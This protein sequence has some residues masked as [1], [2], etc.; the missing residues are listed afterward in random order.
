[1]RGSANS[2]L[3][4]SLSRSLA[5]SLSGIACAACGSALSS[6]AVPP[7]AVPSE[8]RAEPLVAQAQGRAPPVPCAPGS[9]DPSSVLQTFFKHASS[10]PFRS[11]A[12]DANIFRAT[13][14][15]YLRTRLSRLAMRSSHTRRGRRSA[16]RRPRCTTCRRPTGRRRRPSPTGSPLA[17]ARTSAR[18]C[19]RCTRAFRVPAQVG[20]SA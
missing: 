11:Q 10:I 18:S 13:A 12:A 1:L 16:R 20:G 4:L 14:A 19:S 3:S 17:R 15:R 8:V 7:P 6:A 5:L 2:S 9:K